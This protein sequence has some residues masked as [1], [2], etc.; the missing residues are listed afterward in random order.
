MLGQQ[1]SKD[2]SANSVSDKAAVS[3]IPRKR[4]RSNSLKDPS[5]TFALDTFSSTMDYEYETLS[6][7]DE[8]YNEEDKEEEDDIEIILDPSDL[9]YE[10]QFIFEICNISTF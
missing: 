7:D 1:Q 3:S 9:D 10:N 4:A 6:N 8:E 2:F 5:F